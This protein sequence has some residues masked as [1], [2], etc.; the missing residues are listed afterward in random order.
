[1]DTVEAMTRQL[2]NGDIEFYLGVTHPSQP[3]DR[4][5]VRP[6]G[7]ATPRMLVRPGHPLTGIGP[8]QIKQLLEFPKIA[9]SS[10]N[11]SMQYIEMGEHRDALR[12]SIE[13]DGYELLTKIVLASDSILIG[14]FWDP[15][16]GLELLEVADIHELP[17]SS[18]AI[19]ALRARTQ[20]P[21]ALM[22]SDRLALAYRASTPFGVRPGPA[23]MLPYA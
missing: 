1:M 11:D 14:S 5:H 9:V 4:L 6:L 2:L 23:Q 10:W 21:A 12:A 8:V 7:S 3:L 16:E 13:L 19:F 20:S 17:S 22:L 18:V 15:Q